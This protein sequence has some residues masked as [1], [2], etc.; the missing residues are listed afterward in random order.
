MSDEIKMTADEDTLPPPPDSHPVDERNPYHAGVRAE[1]D[2]CGELT[3][4]WWVPN[5]YRAEINDDWR[6]MWLCDDCEENARMDI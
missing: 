4:C 6:C 1:C 5:P 2:C 3:L